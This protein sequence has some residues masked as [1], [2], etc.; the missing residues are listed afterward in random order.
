MEPTAIQQLQIVDRKPSGEVSSCLYAPLKACSSAHKTFRDGS[1]TVKID[2]KVVVHYP[3]HLEVVPASEINCLFD[4]LFRG[5]RIPLASV[6]TCIRTVAT[7][8][9][10]GEAGGIHGPPLAAETFIGV[11]V[12]EMIGLWRHI[13][14]GPEDPLRSEDQFVVALEPDTCNEIRCGAVL[15]MTDKIQER[16]FALSAYN[17][18]DIGRLERLRRQ[19]RGM[20]S[21]KNDGKVRIPFF[22]CF[23]DFNCFPDHWS[24]NQRNP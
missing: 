9:R 7:V 16:F 10:A 19:Q 3:Q 13:H 11:E 22:D 24:G 21:P 20:P 4:K 8:I 17:I 23:C 18:V 12:G 15:D 6:D 5:Q 1:C 14:E 2:Q